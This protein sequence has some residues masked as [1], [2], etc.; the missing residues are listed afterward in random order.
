[1]AQEDLYIY[2]LL[3]TPSIY[4]CRVSRSKEQVN[5]GPAGMLEADCAVH[6]LCRHVLVSYP[7]AALNVFSFIKSVPI[8]YAGLRY[9]GVCLKKE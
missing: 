2:T 4:I 3:R 9:S 1:M 7:C 8:K 6:E 5:L